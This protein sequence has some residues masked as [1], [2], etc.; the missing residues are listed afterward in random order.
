VRRLAARLAERAGLDEAQRGNASIVAMELATNLSRYAPGGELLLRLHDDGADS[1]GLEMLSVDR[2]PGMPNLDRCLE[3][4]FS[5]GGTPGNGLGAIRRLSTEFDIYSTQPGG[6]VVFSRIAR[7]PADR[8]QEPTPFRWGAVSRPAPGEVLCGDTWR[9]GHRAGELT[10]MIADGL[11]HGALAAEASGVAGALFDEDQFPVLTDF[12]AAAD[13]RMRG[14]RGAALAI[15]QVD[16]QA[17]TVGFA[18]V[19]NIAG[20]LRPCHA[21]TG[22]GLVSHN[23]TVGAEMRKVQR[24][25]YDCPPEALLVMHSDGLQHRWNL[26]DLPGAAGRHPAVLAALLY[27]D[28]TRGRDDV[29][30]CVVRVSSARMGG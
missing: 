15:A 10:L 5:T 6:T 26:K 11:G 21:P 3:D 29:T 1:L 19:G 30:V 23:G 18:G 16:R 7:Q 27:R 25:D 24:F 12:V 9:I 4:G 14:T 17:N 20:T 8:R 2:G 22:Q 28:F 13:R